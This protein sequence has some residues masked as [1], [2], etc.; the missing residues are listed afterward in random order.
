MSESLGSSVVRTFARALGSLDATDTSDVERIDLIRALEELKGAAAVAQA[1]VTVAFD[2]SQRRAQRDAGMPERRI[3]AGVAAQV[4]LARR[5]SPHAGARHLGLAHALVDELP[6]T[7]TALAA[8]DTSEWRATLV[9]RETACLSRD[10]RRAVDAGL[11]ARRG[12]IGSLGDGELVAEA[13]R[14][15]YRLDPRAVTDRAARAH[16]DRRVTLRPAPDTMAAL[17][18]LLPA[19]QGVAVYAALTRHADTLRP[20]A[21]VAVAARSWLTRWSSA[22]RGRAGPTPSPSRCAW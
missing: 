2:D 3:G 16:T 7:M 12:G 10:D 9:A 1:R 13:R 19:A 8:G 5:E 20:R 18:A 6:Q 14:L 21:T 4:A 17:S 22:S 15:G 11:A